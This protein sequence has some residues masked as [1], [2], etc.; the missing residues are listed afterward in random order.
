[1]RMKHAEGSEIPEMLLSPEVVLQVEMDEEE[2]EEGLNGASEIGSITDPLDMPGTAKH[3]KPKIC[4]WVLDDG[5]VCGKSFARNDTLTQHKRQVHKGIRPHACHLCEKSYGR[6]DYLD[7]HIMLAHEK[8]NNAEMLPSR[9]IHKARQL[10]ADMDGEG[11]DGK[12]TAKH[13]EQHF[14]RWVRDD[15]AMCEKSF[16]TLDSLKRHMTALHMGKRPHRCNQCGKGY[17]RRDYLDRHIMLTHGEANDAE[18]SGRGRYRDRVYPKP[19]SP[20]VLLKVE[21]DEDGDEGLNETFEIGSISEP[22]VVVKAEMDEVVEDGEETVKH[23]KHHICRWVLDDGELCGRSFTKLDSLK[24]HREALHKGNRPHSCHLCS[25]SYGRKDYLDRHIM[26]VHENDNSPEKLL[27]P[28]VL[29]KVEMEEQGDDGLNDASEVGSM[30]DSDDVPIAIANSYSQKRSKRGEG[31]EICTWV[32]GNG[33]VCGR[34]FTKPDSLKQHRRQIHKGFRPHAC[35]LCGKSYGRRDYLDRHIV[36]SHEKRNK[37]SSIPN[38]EIRVGNTS[39]LLYD[40]PEETICPKPK[41]C[42]WVLEDGEVCGKSFS[43]R[44]NLRLHESQVHKGIRPF[45]CHLCDMSYGRKDYLER[46]IT[47]A[48]E[49]ANDAEISPSSEV[50]LKFEMDEEGEEGFQ[51]NKFQ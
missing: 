22:Q 27:S 10:K 19:P 47:V 28:E 12:K 21:M 39:N 41:I 50:L 18:V 7:R 3:P 33:S 49:K 38:P 34:R 4:R 6:K 15:G 35:H 13:A 11:E 8:V 26:R 40:P 5:E 51:L 9:G 36:L 31:T 24:K 2:G 20:E 16:T 25:K 30:P 43:R 45:A 32:L 1:M 17:G 48:H 14:C 46:H 44:D 37:V 29:L 42:Q 23:S